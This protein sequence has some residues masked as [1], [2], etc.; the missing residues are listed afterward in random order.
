MSLLHKSSLPALAGLYERWAP[1]G[2]A[3][4]CSHSERGAGEGILLR[5]LFG[6]VPVPGNHHSHRQLDRDLVQYTHIS[7]SPSRT[8][9]YFSFR[10]SANVTS[11]ILP[12]QSKQY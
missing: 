1:E 10:G 12:L 11:F 5:M 2:D 3:N 6:H 4:Y 7:G 8:V 9:P